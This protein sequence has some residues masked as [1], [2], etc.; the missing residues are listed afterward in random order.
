MIKCP[1]LFEFGVIDIVLLSVPAASVGGLAG[2]RMAELKS[3]LR[4]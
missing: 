1:G 3:T 2:V 4:S